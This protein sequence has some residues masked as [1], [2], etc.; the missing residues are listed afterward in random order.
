MH[1]VGAESEEEIRAKLAVDPWSGSHLV[2]D[3]IDPWKIRLDGREAAV[4]ERGS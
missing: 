4:A 2:V 3:T 1:A